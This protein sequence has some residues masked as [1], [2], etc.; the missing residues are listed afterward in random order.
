MHPTLSNDKIRSQTTLTLPILKADIG[1]QMVIPSLTIMTFSAI[2]HRFN[3]YAVAWAYP[4]HTGAYL[5]NFS[6]DFVS[7]RNGQS[8]GW[9][10]P[11][12]DMYIRAA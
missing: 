2:D 3:C 6:G 7:Y 1:T 11:F 4:G 5:C 9:M 12:I 8:D 10:L